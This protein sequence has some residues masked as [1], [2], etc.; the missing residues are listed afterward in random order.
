MIAAGRGAALTRQLLAFGRRQ[1]LDP[2]IVDINHVVGDIERMTRRL[3]GDAITVSYELDPDLGLVLADESQLEQI[4]LN[5]AI[6]ASDAM[7]SGGSLVIS[8]QNVE[9]RSLPEALDL[10]PG[11]YVRLAVTDTG[12][13]MNVATVARALE[14]F[15]TTKADAHGTG[16]GLAMVAGVVAQLGGGVRIISEPDVGTTV[17]VSFPRAYVDAADR[18][19]G[20]PEH[21]PRGSERILLV[22]DESVIRRLL[23]E[24]LSDLGYVVTAADSGEGAIAEFGASRFDAVVT[25]WMMPGMTGRALVDRLAELGSKLP[26]LFVSGYAPGRVIEKPGGDESFLQKPFTCDELAHQLRDLLDRTGVVA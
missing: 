4:I 9:L 17:S 15:F 3:V 5:L 26:V 23:T 24:I 14:P 12:H 21:V 16:L 7:P 1:A 13:G 18:S 11:E 19:H 6:N 25:D 10:E 8:T 20:D 22:E 2:T